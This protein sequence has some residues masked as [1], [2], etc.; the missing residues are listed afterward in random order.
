M[1]QL[2]LIIVKLPKVLF[3]VSFSIISF[4][5]NTVINWVPVIYS[6]VS[7]ETAQHTCVPWYLMMRFLRL[8]LP[9]SRA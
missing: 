1:Q 7:N 9:C 2:V 8:A 6:L 5:L 4:Q 3:W